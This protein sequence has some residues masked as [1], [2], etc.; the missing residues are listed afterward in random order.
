MTVRLGL[1]LLLNSMQV[2]QPWIEERRHELA[3]IERLMSR[4][5][6][7]VHNQTFEAGGLL[8]DDGSPNVDRIKRLVQPLSFPRFF[9]IALLSSLIHLLAFAVSLRS[10]ILIITNLYHNLS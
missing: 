9:F 2:V 3:K 4:I 10:L 8:T 7:H 5:L 1:S 6:K